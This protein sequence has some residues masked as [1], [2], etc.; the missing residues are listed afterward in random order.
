[1]GVANK[2]EAGIETVTKTGLAIAHELKD[3]KSNPDPSPVKQP[4]YA[5]DPAMSLVWKE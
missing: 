4:D 2:V 5:T 3:N 1:M